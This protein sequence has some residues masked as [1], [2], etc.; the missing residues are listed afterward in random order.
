MLMLGLS[1]VM[2]VHLLLA[3]VLSLLL[4]LKLLALVRRWLLV[5]LILLLLLLPFS[6]LPRQPLPLLLVVATVHEGTRPLSTAATTATP[7]KWGGR[8]EVG[9]GSFKAAAPRPASTRAGPPSQLHRP[10]LI[11]RGV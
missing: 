7:T 9:K 10:A 8:R 11:A 4:L 5:V 3:A 1:L 2:R 6:L